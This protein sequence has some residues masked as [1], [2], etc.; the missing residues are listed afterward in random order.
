MQASVAVA[1]SLA[2]ATFAS[3]DLACIGAGLLAARGE[4]G[5]LTGI[6]GCAAGIVAGDL[7]LWVAGRAFG[8]TALRWRWLGARVNQARLERMRHWLEQN[9]ARAI[10]ASRFLPGSRLPLYVT[11]GIS[12]MS[13]VSF[14][15]WVLVG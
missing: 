5:L 8:T 7:G 12:R 11:A 4:V 6:A 1:L 2:V 14:A 9:A 10:L 15:G 3:E 13:V